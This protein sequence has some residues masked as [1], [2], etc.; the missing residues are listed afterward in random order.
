MW[1]ALASQLGAACAGSQVCES[2]FTGHEGSRLHLLGQPRVKHILGPAKLA[3]GQVS[4]LWKFVVLPHPPQ[5]ADAV[6]NALI[7]QVPERDE[8]PGDWRFGARRVR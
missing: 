3:L 6:V 5:M 8:A 4:G 1:L 2:N 7:R